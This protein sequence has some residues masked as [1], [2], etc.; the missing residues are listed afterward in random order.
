MNRMTGIDNRTHGIRIAAVSTKRAVATLW[1]VASLLGY[2]MQVHAIAGSVAF[3]A[4]A[5]SRLVHAGRLTNWFVPRVAP[6][7]NSA[8]VN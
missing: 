3:C 5:V 8:A 6:V 2:S 7:A 1:L 4:A